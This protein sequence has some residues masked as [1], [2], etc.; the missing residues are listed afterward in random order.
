MSIHY[1]IIY[2]RDMPSHLKIRNGRERLSVP[3][4]AR[5]QTAIHRAAYRAKAI[6]GEGYMQA[7][8]SSSWIPRE[9]DP[10]AAANQLLGE[11]DAQ[12]D[13]DKLDQ[14]ARNKGYDTKNGHR[15]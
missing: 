9:G 12:Y 7:W 13:S 11:L 1:K 4:S 10:H 14:L 8:N 3:L 15:N 2:W 6:S 5:F